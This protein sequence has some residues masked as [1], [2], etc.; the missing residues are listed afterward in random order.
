MEPARDWVEIDRTADTFA[1][2]VLRGDR[3]AVEKFVAERAIEAGRAA[4]DLAA[5]K[6]PF[7]RFE[8]LARARIER[9]FI[10]KIR[11]HGEK[12]PATWQTRW[13]LDGEGRWQIVEI[14][15]LMAQASSSSSAPSTPNPAT[16]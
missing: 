16:N 1:G 9:Q 3:V 6:R 2:A 8:V 7:A 12:G 4:S 10:V 11:W 13:D 14:E 15:D 5:A